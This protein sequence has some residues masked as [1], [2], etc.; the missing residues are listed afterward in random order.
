MWVTFTFLPVLSLWKSHLW[1]LLFCIIYQLTTASSWL[2]S[3]HIFPSLCLS[4][5]SAVKKGFLWKALQ[6]PCLLSE[7]LSLSTPIPPY[8]LPSWVLVI[9]I[10]PRTRCTTVHFVYNC[11]FLGTFILFSLYPWPRC[12]RLKVK[13]LSLHS[14][15][16][17]ESDMW[18]EAL[19]PPDFWPQK[20][21]W[22]AVSP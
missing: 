5:D 15:V 19:W 17:L 18:L 1:T 2:T 11:N 8:V 3:D 9:N 10:P 6:I 16:S 20:Q 21:T 13:I 22:L 7:L 12:C 4:V 14:R